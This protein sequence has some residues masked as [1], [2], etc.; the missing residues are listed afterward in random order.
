MPKLKIM[1]YNN[2]ISEYT[3]VTNILGGQSILLDNTLNY[4]KGGTSV[5]DITN[6]NK[7]GIGM[8]F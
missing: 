1:Y 6:F 2:D 3:D 5:N 8:Y 7:S 4:T